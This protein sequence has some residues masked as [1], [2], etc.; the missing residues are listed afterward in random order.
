M[1]KSELEW[2]EA[3]LARINRAPFF[4]RP[5]ARRKVESAAR[6]KGLTRITLE[7]L[8]GIKQKEMG[9]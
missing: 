8:E 5:L 9:R 6:E 1:S 4:I 3:A 2:D 7:F